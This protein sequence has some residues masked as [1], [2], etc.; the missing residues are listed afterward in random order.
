MGDFQ[1][2]EVAGGLGRYKGA[3]FERVFEHEVP[4]GLTGS[5]NALRDFDLVVNSY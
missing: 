1:A 5:E 3:I 4:A 2:L